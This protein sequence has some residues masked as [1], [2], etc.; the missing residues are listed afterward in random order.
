MH[1]ALK[2]ELRPSSS[3]ASLMTVLV[4][5]ERSTGSSHSPLEDSG[6]RP[7]A[8]RQATMQARQP[9]HLVAS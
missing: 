9:M 7:F 8:S 1:C 5:A 4:L 2:K 6:A 3:L